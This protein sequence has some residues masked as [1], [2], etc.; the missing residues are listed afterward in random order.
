MVVLYKIKM[1]HNAQICIYVF[2]YS[3][4]I[5]F[6]LKFSNFFVVFVLLKYVCILFI[7]ILVKQNLKWKCSFGNLLK[8]IFEIFYFS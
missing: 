6:L 1:F 2:S 8:Y 7:S 5:D 4:F 3:V